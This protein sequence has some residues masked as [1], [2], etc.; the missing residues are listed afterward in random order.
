V[1]EDALITNLRQEHAAR[2]AL[3]ATQGALAALE[4]GLGE[5]LLAVDLEG[6]LLALGDIVG[7]TTPDDLL[8]RIFAEFCI[9]K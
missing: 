1:L 7:V 9:G 6:V 5:E 8:N 4:Q 3:D 2:Q